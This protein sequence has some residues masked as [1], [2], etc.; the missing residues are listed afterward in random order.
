[1]TPELVRQIHL[2]ARS[3]GAPC[4]PQG[5]GWN[6]RSDRT[7]ERGNGA[8]SGVSASSTIAAAA[9]A[10]AN[11]NQPSST[12]A[13]RNGS[14]GNLPFSLS[15][16]EMAVGL[17][18]GTT[19]TIRGIFEQPARSD[20]LLQTQHPSAPFK[21]F[22]PLDPCAPVAPSAPSAQFA[23][24]RGFS[25]FQQPSG[26]PP[27]AAAAETGQPV[28]RQPL[29]RRPSAD[30]AMD[31][32]AEVMT[33]PPSRRGVKRTSG[34]GANSANNNTTVLP[35]T[36][37]APAS[38]ARRRRSESNGPSA[39]DG[40]SSGGS[41]SGGG[42]SPR[43]GEEPAEVGATAPSAAAEATAA[44]TAAW[45]QHQ[46]SRGVAE[47]VSAD[48]HRWLK[49]GAKKLSTKNGG[50]RR[51]YYRCAASSPHHRS[52][53]SAPCPARKVVNSHPLRPFD[54][55][56]VTVEYLSEHNHPVEGGRV[57]V[58]DYK[59]RRVPLAGDDGAAGGEDRVMVGSADVS[60]A[61]AADG[62]AWTAAGGGAA[63]AAAA[64]AAGDDRVVSHDESPFEEETPQLR[65]FMAPP[66]V[67]S[68]LFNSPPFSSPSPH[69]PPLLQPL[70]LQPPLPSPLLLA[71]P[72][73]PD[74]S[75]LPPP[76]PPP[77]PPFSARSYYSVD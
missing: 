9:S 15:E 24:S 73:P 32:S 53:G 51:A 57:V 59:G 12:F 60:P 41:S 55:S 36:A 62:E 8:G 71:F 63:A 16:R 70:L 4:F 5:G 58:R 54:L 46:W 75:P 38:A 2:L 27:L 6:T 37:T 61:V 64:A 34:P 28:T 44:A 29:T 48:G 65:D 69:L 42:D 1:M 77:H 3:Q 17:P 72:R 11:H 30:G 19:A 33:V 10:A 25:A 22:A 7:D 74:L 49:Y 18:G 50:Q 26:F 76:L 21:S 13:D 67:I 56:A 23:T 47:L 45:E 52:A 66:C 14:F 40:A 39:G 35:A 20:Y 31:T 43:A 68:F